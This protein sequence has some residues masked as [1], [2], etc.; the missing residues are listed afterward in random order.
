MSVDHT[1]EKVDIF[2]SASQLPNIRTFRY[3]L[4]IPRLQ[5]SFVDISSVQTYAVVY[6]V[7]EENGSFT[8]VG[9][10]VWKLLIIFFMSANIF[11]LL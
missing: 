4:K 2:V 9:T 11:S 6:A 3:F 10:T 1:I 7:N 5:D 8:K